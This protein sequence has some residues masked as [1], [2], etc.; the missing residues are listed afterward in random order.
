MNPVS[1]CVKCAVCHGGPVDKQSRSIEADVFIRCLLEPLALSFLLLN[2]SVE[3]S[4]SGPAASCPG[5]CDSGPRGSWCGM[6]QESGSAPL[7]FQSL[8]VTLGSSLER[9]SPCSAAWCFLAPVILKLPSL[10]A[11]LCHSGLAAP[12]Q[13]QNLTLSGSMKT[14]RFVRENDDI[15]SARNEM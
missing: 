11:P 10:S 6:S 14:V 1:Q 3:L 7:L 4:C 2:D 5:C 8:E 13:V 12:G 9:P 15:G